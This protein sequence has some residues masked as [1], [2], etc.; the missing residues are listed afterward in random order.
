[1]KRFKFLKKLRVGN[2]RGFTL[3]EAMVAIVVFSVGV[4]AM[5]KMET[6][7][8]DTNVLAQQTTE[9]AAEAASVI[10][11]LNPLDYLKD[12]ELANGT[13]TLP[14]VDQYGVSYTVTENS[15]INH[16]KLI[17]V[18]VAWKIRGKD[19]SVDLVLIKPDII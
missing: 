2:N 9:G 3:I 1:M 18:T 6:N 13:I 14:D 8:I 15:I 4:T 5:A 7:S 10:E 11:N 17:Q 12:A 19:K 16:T